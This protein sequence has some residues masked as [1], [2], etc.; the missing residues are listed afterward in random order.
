MDDLSKEYVITFF[1]RR[2]E[3]FGD[4]PEALA[5]S[6]AGRDARYRSLLDIDESLAGKKVLDFGCGTGDFYGFLIERGIQVKY[7]GLDLNG[8]MISMAK[9][10]YPECTFRTFDI[11][12]DDLD[13]DYDYIFLCGVFNL[14]VKGLDGT[15]R[16]TMKKLYRHC[17]VS[18]AF[19]GLSA[20]DPQKS[21]ELNY[22]S[23]E[24]IFRFA[25]K[26][27]SPH[28]MLRH[29]RIPYDFSLF[30]YRHRNTP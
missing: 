27:L 15:I 9:T 29:D 26:E 16:E 20:H 8:D 3:R 4:V 11:D 14:R 24:E 30:V 12:Q 6:G 21:F 2:L 5:W 17:R 25:V 19:N 13:E 23:P 7:T 18:M 1:S 22:L 10:K 28:V